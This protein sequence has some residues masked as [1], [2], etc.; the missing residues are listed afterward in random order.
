[1]MDKDFEI[2]DEYINANKD[3]GL[4]F[5]DFEQWIDQVEKNNFIDNINKI[6]D[7]KSRKRFIKTL[8]LNCWINS[9]IC[10]EKNN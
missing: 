7:A 9:A 6:P 8:L 10:Y 2:F 4:V 3:C 1:M 5:Q